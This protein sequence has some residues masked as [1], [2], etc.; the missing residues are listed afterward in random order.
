MDDHAGRSAGQIYPDGKGYPVGVQRDASLFNVQSH[1]SAREVANVK[2][3]RISDQACCKER[4]A[5]GPLACRCVVAAVS[6]G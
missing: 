4:L 5:R 3:W 2:W 6:T 1:Q